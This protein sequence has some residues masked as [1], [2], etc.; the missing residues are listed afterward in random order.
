MK[1]KD[2]VIKIVAFIVSYIIFVIVSAIGAMFWF[3]NKW[4]EEI[5]IIV[6]LIVAIGLFLYT[7]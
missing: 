7:R 4:W 1:T 2:K 6:L 3:C 5:L